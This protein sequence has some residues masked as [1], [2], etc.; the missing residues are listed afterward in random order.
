M[1]SQRDKGWVLNN[2]EPLIDELVVST[3]LLF[4]IV[5]VTDMKKQKDETAF[6]SCRSVA[7]FLGVSLIGRDLEVFCRIICRVIDY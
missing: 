2:G 4:R 5:M 1:W 6:L 7:L 3:G